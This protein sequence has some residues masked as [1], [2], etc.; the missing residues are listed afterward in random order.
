MVINRAKEADVLREG[1]LDS[2]TFFFLGGLK[3]RNGLN[4]CFFPDSS[5]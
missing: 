2:S 5:K 3:D 1:N 4:R